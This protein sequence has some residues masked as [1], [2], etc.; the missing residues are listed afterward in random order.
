[1]KLPR[2][3]MQLFYFQVSRFCD[4]SIRQVWK[5]YPL[6]K[7]QIKVYYGKDKSKKYEVDF[8][9]IVDH[10]PTWDWS[11]ELIRNDDLLRNLGGSSSRDQDMEG[12][13]KSQKKIRIKNST[14]IVNYCKMFL[15]GYYLFFCWFIYKN[16][17]ILLQN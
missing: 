4:C 1:M 9:S 15:L 5:S 11:N 3:L 2:K 17:Y 12:G 8:K 7:C 6:I 16:F 14:I 10:A 13:E